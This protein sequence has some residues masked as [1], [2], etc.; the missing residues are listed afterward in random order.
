MTKCE[1]RHILVKKFEDAQILASSFEVIPQKK[2]IKQFFYTS[3]NVP[4]QCLF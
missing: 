4:Y 3:L 1:A 2:V